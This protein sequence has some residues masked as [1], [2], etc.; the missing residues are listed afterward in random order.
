VTELSTARLVL[1]QWRGADLEP[2]A[3]LNADLEVMQYFPAPL[4]RRQSDALA[5]RNQGT[6]ARQ[7]WG[8]WAVEVIDGPPF[9][10][11]VGL[12]RATFEARFTPAVEVGW[13]LAR[14][15]WGNGY[16]TEAAAAAIEWGFDRLRLDQIVSF[17]AAVNERSSRVMERLGM[18]RDPTDDF[19]H[20][21]VSDGPLRRHVLFRSYGGNRVQTLR[22]GSTL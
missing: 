21:L 8:L 1:R 7:G 11:F 3:A 10:G 15:Y 12:N 19:D 4:T 22:P 5:A 20:P 9:I 17:T 18:T 13:R 6:I 2:F 16:A 14:G